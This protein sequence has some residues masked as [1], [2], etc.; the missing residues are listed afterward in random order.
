MIPFLLLAL[1]MRHNRFSLCS[2]VESKM[3]PNGVGKKSERKAESNAVRFRYESEPDPI[4][5][6]TE[7]GVEYGEI[8]I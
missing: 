7:S 8:S 3:N 5:I 2:E 6:R 4:E 1:A